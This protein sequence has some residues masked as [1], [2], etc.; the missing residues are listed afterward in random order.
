MCAWGASS[1]KSCDDLIARIERNDPELTDLIILPTKSFGDDELN[2]LSIVLE[3]AAET[4]Y[5]RSF[6]ASGHVVSTLA[7]ARI[8]AAIAAASASGYCQLQAV[9]IGHFATG[10]EGIQAF[11]SGL[12]SGEKPSQC[13]L[14]SLDLSLKGMGIAGLHALAQLS[15]VCPNIQVLNVSRNTLQLG[16]ANHGCVGFV[17]PPVLFRHVS[18]LDLSACDLDTSFARLLFPLFS[19]CAAIRTLRLENNPLCDGGLEAALQVANLDGLFVSNCRLTDTAMDHL[20]SSVSQLAE[21]HNLDFS[22][23][24][25]T[26]A[27]A[28]VLGDLLRQVATPESQPRLQLRDINVSGNCIDA[29][30]V[31]AVVNGAMALWGG[32]GGGLRSMD[33]SETVCGTAGAVAAVRSSGMMGLVSLRLYNNKLG[34]T[35]F[36]A[37]AETLPLS[38]LKNSSLEMLD[39]AGNG[40][41]QA[42]VAALLRALLES[43]RNDSS[44]SLKCLIVGGNQGGEDVE[45]VIRQIH[46]LRPNLDI[47]RDKIKKH[48]SK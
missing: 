20:A 8:G 38:L 22:G 19:S 7:L 11:A 14:T 27:G 47:A 13:S 10:D 23:N 26:A 41:D 42:A 3:T 45:D 32:G 46:D 25:L 21:C 44:L 39:L 9:S 48:G 31:Q 36:L 24:G 33:F 1:S 40:A 2:R 43:L 4:L 29:E 6:A 30:G 34:S 35:G 16:M 18:H 17:L 12:L 28:T 15:E 37:L 5:W